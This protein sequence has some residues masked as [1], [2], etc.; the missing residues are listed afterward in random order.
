[1][2]LPDRPQALRIEFGRSLHPSLHLL[3]PDLEPRSI[4]P[5]PS[6][7]KSGHISLLRGTIDQRRDRE[8]IARPPERTLRHQGS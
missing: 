7:A 3:K 5:V 6:M 4:I 1:M 2:P 8:D